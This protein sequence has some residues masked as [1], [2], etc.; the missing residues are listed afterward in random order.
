VEQETGENT[1][2]PKKVEY[3][4][5]IKARLGSF[6]LVEG[7]LKLD[8]AFFSDSTRN[9]KQYKL[10]PNL[11]KMLAASLA[12]EE[13]TKPNAYYLKEFYSIES[14]KKNKKYDEFLEKLDIGQTKDANCYALSRIEFGDSIAALL[15][16]LDF[17]SYEACPYFQG[18]H[19]LLSTVYNG[20]VV[21]TIQVGAD[22]SAAD[23][24]VSSTILQEAKISAQGKLTYKY[25]SSVDEE[26]RQIEH[27]SEKKEF[28]LTPEGFVKK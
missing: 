25:E 11:V 18:S 19:Y 9:H 20:K 8:K 5:G 23:A 14:A 12:D 22:E 15:W 10:D 28:L 7:E 3:P 1:E 2:K 6:P 26:D 27:S 13:L 17:S 21:Q 4:S 16:R 24:P